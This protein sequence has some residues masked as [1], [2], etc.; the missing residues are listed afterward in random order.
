M[1]VI[2]TV[3]GVYETYYYCVL[4]SHGKRVGRKNSTDNIADTATR[5]QLRVTQTSSKAMANA[6]SP[7]PPTACAMRSA[8]RPPVRDD[9]QLDGIRTHGGHSASALVSS[10]PFRSAGSIVGAFDMHTD[11]V[12]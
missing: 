3:R 11:L 8:Q 12:W 10:R 2:Y 5:H 4:A 9:R 7:R 1:A 6:L